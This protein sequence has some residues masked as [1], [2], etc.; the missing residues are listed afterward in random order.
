M[1]W[2]GIVTLAL[3]LSA[4]A[5][6]PAIA[7]AQK[8]QGMTAEDLVMLYRVADP[9]VS[10]NGRE[11][12]FVLRSTDREGNAA[13]TDLW[14]LRLG[15]KNNDLRPLTTHAESS[16]NPRWSADGRSVYFI[17]ARSGSAQ[18]WSLAV[19]SGE[20]RMITSL[21]LPVSALAVSQAGNALAFSA[22]VFPDCPDMLCSAGRLKEMQRADETGL[23]YDRLIMRF[24]D[25]WRDGRQQQL[26]TLALDENGLA[27]GEPVNVSAPL[28]GDVPAR[29]FGSSEAFAFSPDGNRIFFALKVQD[30]NESWS[31]NSDIYAAN[32]DGSGAPENLTADNPASDKQPIVSPN[33]RRLAWL[34]T[35]GP[36]RWAAENR[37]RVRDLKTGEERIL[38]PRWDRSPQK[39]AFS[40]DG[41]SILATADHK[42]T[43]ALWRVPVNGGNP[44]ILARGG[45]INE[46]SAASRQLVFTRNDLANPTDLFQ[47]TSRAREVGGILPARE[48]AIKPRRLT[49]LN[50]ERMA[51]LKT[52]A[53]E[54]FR[55]AGADGD[56]VYA[57]LVRPANYE[58]GRKYPLVLMLHGGPHGSMGDQF[59]YRWNAQVLAGA[60]YGVL[61]IDFHGSTGYGQK[62]VESIM[63]DRGGKT[64]TDQKLGLAAALARYDWIDG[65]RVCAIGGSFGGYMV[66]WIAGAWPDR[67]R[68]LVNHDGMFD[69]RM[70]Y[71]T[72]DFIGYLEEGFG[73]TY[74]DNPQGH[75]SFNP[76]TLVENW[77][78]PMLVIHGGRDYRV[79]ET[80]G[81]A[82]FT[83]LQRQ[84]I[85][86]RYLAFADENHWVLKPA[87]SLQWYRE[88]IGWL[89][90]WT[91]DLQ[92]KESR[93]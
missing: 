48:L 70:K 52:G 11:L 31:L 45:W 92:E 1:R 15:K 19:E 20:A 63:E 81:I 51:G 83:A 25:Q 16:I 21:P 65:Q 32:T 60:G 79:P 72:S 43:R 49:A 64:L 87:N 23:T 75:E 34:A 71:F 44:L 61:M 47:I 10:P 93:K 18:V 69:N 26:F 50:R 55:F 58:K 13:H 33:G 27:V 46:F 2:P 9:R 77:Q 29:P 30:K 66:N 76:V 57:F 5:A 68:C 22:D 35:N 4:A 86:S 7:E 37:I 82:A 3:L 6:S 53:F 67:F 38:A 73:G 54:Q 84:G 88:V 90:R 78:T 24:W 28:A 74:F 91:N 41:R 8:R 36:Q 89:N 59:H 42:G 40:P 62:F 56:D 17:S 85:P 80:Q 12:V 14:H 39:I